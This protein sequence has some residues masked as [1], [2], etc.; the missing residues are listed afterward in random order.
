MTTVSLKINGH[1]F[2]ASE[3]DMLLKVCRDNGFDIPTMC[4]N[5]AVEPDGRCRLCSVEVSEGRGRSRVVVSCNY[6]AREGLEVQTHS[7]RVMAVRKLVIELLAARC[8][9]KPQVTGFAK[10]FGVAKPRYKPLDDVCILCGLCARVCDQVVGVHALSLVNRGSTKWA[11]TPFFEASKDCIG[12]GTCN[13]VCPTD[14]IGME[15][16]GD[17]RVFK[18][19][20]TE[21]TM[22]KCKVCGNNI[23]PEYQLEYIRKKWNLPAD[24]F[25]V[26]TTCRV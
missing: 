21:F 9:T 5:E 22:K 12:C 3:G 8:P 6:P 23:A 19:W 26:C 1:P 25:D 14:C 17:K 2:Q 20:N 16:V 18:K 13:Y 24:H 11:S 4:Y 15:D 10:R 7:P